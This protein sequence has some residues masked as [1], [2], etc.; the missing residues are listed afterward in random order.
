MSTVT[1]IFTGVEGRTGQ[2]ITATSDPSTA[3]CI[4]FLNEAIQWILSLCVESKSELGRTTGTITTTSTIAS[5]SGLSTMYAPYEFG[6][7][8]KTSSRV[9]IDLVTEEDTLDFNPSNTAE[10]TKFYIDG[11]NNVIFLDTPNDAYTIK[12]PY[13]PTPT[14]LTAVGNT[15]PFN[16]LFDNLLIEFLTMRIQNRDEYD[17]SF[18][19][20]WLQF[21]LTGAKRIIAIRKG[22]KFGVSL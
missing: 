17:L 11:S 18:E 22:T 5:Y 19:Y 21:L 3:T 8:V 16:G 2:S 13:W 7:I 10:P 4:Q 15:V 1:N 6:W 12:I 14:T 9:R 20:K